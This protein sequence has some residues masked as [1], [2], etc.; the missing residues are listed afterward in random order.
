MYKEKT[1]TP[2]L[3]IIAMIS[4]SI[5]MTLRIDNLADLW[6]GFLFFVVL[7]ILTESFTVTI[8]KLQIAVTPAILVATLIL[9]GSATTV[10]VA[11]IASTACI[12]KI[13]GKLRHI[14]NNPAKKNN[15]KY[16]DC[17]DINRSIFFVL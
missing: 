16:F 5:L 11:F 6:S 17:R 12:T 2:F 4:V 14:L 3:I 9:Y 8:S 7:A 1:K 10:L 13:D 15:Y